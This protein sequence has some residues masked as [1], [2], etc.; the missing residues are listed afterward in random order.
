MVDRLTIILLHIFIIAQPKLYDD[1][2][3]NGKGTPVSF[4]DNIGEYE[5][6]IALS[7]L[8]TS[9]HHVYNGTTNRHPSTT[10]L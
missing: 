8:H 3:S 2:V 1:I 9:I 7:I 10:K 6:L 5:D 4:S